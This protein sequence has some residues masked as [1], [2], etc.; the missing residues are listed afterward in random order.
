MNCVL[1]MQ[2]FQPFENL[3]SVCSDQYFVK[4]LKSL[5]DGLK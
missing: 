4:D 2:I 5:H 3:P 1:C